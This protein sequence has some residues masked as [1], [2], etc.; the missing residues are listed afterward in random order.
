MRMIEM[1]TA[2]LLAGAMKIGAL[3]A[4]ASDEDAEH[5]YQFGRKIGIAFQLQDDLLDSFGDAAKFGKKVG[6][7]IIQNKKTYLVLR[8]LELADTATQEQLLKLLANQ[9]LP[10]KE[11]VEAVK[12]LFTQLQIP[13]ATNKLKAQY[14][15]EAM[16]HLKQIGVAESKKK[17]I[18]DLASKMLNREV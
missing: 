7:D 11:K 9:T 4:H 10:E 3:A 8:S 15:D 18:R 16:E 6:G 14:Q 17:A 1:K 2:V 12:G 5:A 13:E